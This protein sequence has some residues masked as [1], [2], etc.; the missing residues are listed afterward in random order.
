MTAEIPAWGWGSKVGGGHLEVIHHYHGVY[1]TV[2]KVFAKM[3]GFKAAA[4]A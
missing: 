3:A 4:N 1:Q 2:E